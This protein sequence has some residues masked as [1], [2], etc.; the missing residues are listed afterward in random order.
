MNSNQALL[1]NIGI[2]TDDQMAE[3]DT[4]DA[5]SGEEVLAC[6]VVAALAQHGFLTKRLLRQFTGIHASI[7]EAL[8]TALAQMDD[9]TFTDLHRL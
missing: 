6:V 1:N 3:A 2:Y 7:T 8:N 4:Q 9:E 5:L